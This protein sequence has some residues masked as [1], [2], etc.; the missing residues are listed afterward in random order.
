MGAA[1]VV[2]TAYGIAHGTVQLFG[3][4]IG[5][6]FGKYYAVAGLTV[7]A[8]TVVVF[9]CGLAASLPQLVAFRLAERTGLWLRDPAG[10]GLCRRRGA[11]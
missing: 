8:P 2:V 11:V 9:L 6:R 10:D 7:L 1:S 4:E 5:N 3:G